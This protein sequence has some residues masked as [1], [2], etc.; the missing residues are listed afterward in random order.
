MNM[1]VIELLLRALS[2]LKPLLPGMIA[3]VVM[4]VL[5]L[6]GLLLCCKNAWV[7][8]RRFRLVGLFFGLNG[9]CSLRLACAWLKMIFLVVFVVGFQKLFL[10]HYLMILIPGL[11]SVLCGDGFAGRISSLFWLVLQTAGLLSVNLICGYIR[12]LSGSGGFV[13]IYITMSVFL[14]LFSVYLF[15]NEVNAISLQ[16]DVDAEQIWPQFME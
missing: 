16:R 14:I 9:R 4:T 11:I 7:D 13:L 2:E 10:I 12:D 15:L 8:S 6:V 3:A 5:A 1:S